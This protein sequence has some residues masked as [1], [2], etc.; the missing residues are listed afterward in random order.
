[1][2]SISTDLNEFSARINGTLSDIERLRSR[3]ADAGQ[4]IHELRI[5]NN[6]GF[7][8]EDGLL[9]ASGYVGS[10]AMHMQYAIDE[11]AIIA[12]SLK[13]RENSDGTPQAET[14]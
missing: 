2:V 5:R 14:C 11:L 13:T 8:H 3:I 9:E 7:E 12:E 10:A 6:I 1:M 4:D